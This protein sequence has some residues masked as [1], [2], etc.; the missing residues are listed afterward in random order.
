MSSNKNN[1]ILEDSLVSS[2]PFDLDDLPDGLDSLTLGYN[3]EMFGSLFN[4]ECKGL[5]QC[6][7]LSNLSSLTFNGYST[8]YHKF[9]YLPQ[10]LKNLTVGKYYD[11]L[12]DNLPSDLQSLTVEYCSE[13]NDKLIDLPPNL[14]TLVLNR[15]FNSALKLPDNL[16][17]LTL[18]RRFNH[19]LELPSSLLSLTFSHNSKFN[20]ELKFPDNLQSLTLGA[21]FK[22][23]LKKLPNSL[24]SLVISEW[25]NKFK[26]KKLQCNLQDLTL[27]YHFNQKL[28][29]CLVLPKLQILQISNN[30]KGNIPIIF[31]TT[32]II[33]NCVAYGREIKNIKKN[34]IKQNYDFDEWKSIFYKSIK[35]LS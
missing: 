33:I 32:V 1:L 26:L 18:Q 7:R 31:G 10:N 11:T 30:Y 27:G 35:D 22:P 16:Q 17:N 13:F 9:E 23:S 12:L 24:Q 8:N 6:S 19:K 34:E 3:C 2:K 15:N 21:K 25:S 14:H 5:E 4:I 20:K 29:A 28:N